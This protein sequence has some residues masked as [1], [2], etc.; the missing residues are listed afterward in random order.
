MD[1]RIIVSQGIVERGAIAVLQRTNQL[2]MEII[3]SSEA[4]K[5]NSNLEI[6]LWVSCSYQRI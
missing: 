2:R 3:G 4:K 5:S 1:I 6:H